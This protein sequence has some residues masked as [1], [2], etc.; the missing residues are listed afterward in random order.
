MNQALMVVATKS[1]SLLFDI[2]PKITW[3]ASLNGGCHQVLLESL[4]NKSLI[5]MYIYIYIYIYIYLY[6]K[7]R[8]REGDKSTYTRFYLPDL[9]EGNVGNQSCEL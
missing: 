6:F 4:P 7:N 1:Y 5:D 9:F 2:Y 8:E 3:E